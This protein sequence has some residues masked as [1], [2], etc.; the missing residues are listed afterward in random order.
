MASI[1]RLDRTETEVEITSDYCYGQV[2]EALT[3]TMNSTYSPE[4]ANQWRLLGDSLA[5][6]GK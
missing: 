3:S 4:L 6:R 1:K 5:E 2:A